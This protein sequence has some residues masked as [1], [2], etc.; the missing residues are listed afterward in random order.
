V[1][2]IDREHLD[3]YRDLDD[4]QAAFLGFLNK[5]PFYGSGIVC[6]D[7]GPTRDIVAR[8]ERRVLTYGL[9]PQAHVSARDVRLGAESSTYEVT[10]DAAP[11][12]PVRLAVPGAHNVV[13]SLAAVAVGLDLGVPFEK[14][15]EG[16]ESFAGV[17]RRFQ[18]SG[19]VGGITLLDDYGHH[20]TEIRATLETL[21]GRAGKRRTVVVFQPH[22]YSRTRLLWD[23]FCHAFHLADAL[24]LTDIYPA[25]EPPTPGVTAEALA[26]AIA[27][28]GHRRVR[29]VGDVNAAAASVVEEIEEGDVVLTLG[30]GNVGLVGEALLKRLSERVR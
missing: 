19:E 14:V 5:V 1:T 21:R 29:Y 26:A 11:L 22:R 13:N 8:V 4:L 23:E 10:L 18:L 9:S 28:R 6:L 7:D 3:T 27:E 12:G 2:N 15:K 25:S 16:I 17:D 20:P 30:A 24:L